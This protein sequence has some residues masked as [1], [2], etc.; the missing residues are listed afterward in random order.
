MGIASNPNP[1][2]N[3]NPHPHPKPQPQPKPKPKPKPNLEDEQVARVHVG[4][5]PLV[6]EDGGDPRVERR[7]ERELGRRGVGAHRLGRARVRVSLLTE[8]LAYLLTYVRTS[9]PRG[10]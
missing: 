10:R 7:D 3:P 8:L 9:S 4:V 5:E 1:N 2:Y 6:V